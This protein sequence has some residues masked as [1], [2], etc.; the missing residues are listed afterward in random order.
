MLLLLLAAACDNSCN[1]QSHDNALCPEGTVFI[2][3]DAGGGW[4]VTR[5]RAAALAGSLAP[6]SPESEREEPDATPSK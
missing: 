5:E 2:P 3:S 6:G 1:Q 4:C